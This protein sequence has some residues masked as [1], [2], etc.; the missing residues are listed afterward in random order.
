MA[1]PCREFETVRV[2][3]STFKILE[4]PDLAREDVMNK[5]TGKDSLCNASVANNKQLAEETWESRMN[6]KADEFRRRR[7]LM[8]TLRVFYFSISFGRTS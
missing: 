8:K 3:E 1:M 6:E 5:L 2:A 4:L 7:L